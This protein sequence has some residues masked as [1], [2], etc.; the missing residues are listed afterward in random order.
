MGH[1]S[2]VGAGPG[3]ES[4]L[5][6][7]AAELLALADVVIIEQ[8]EQAALVTNGAE[9]VDGGS[10]EDGET[11][12][13]AARARIVVR[14]AKTGAQVVRLVAGDPFTY[15]TAPEEA[16]ACTKAGIGFEIVPGISSV[17]AVP[18]YAGVPLTNRTH[19]EYT[20]VNVG[21]AKVNWSDHAGSDTLV[22]LA[23]VSRIDE[24]ATGLI[25][26]G[27]NA[28][29]P[30]A[31]TRVGTTT[32]QST[33]VSTLQDIAADA[34]AAGMTSPAITVVGAVVSMRETLSW[35]E[36]KPLYG[37]RVLVPRTKEQSAGLARSPAW[38]RCP[39]R[40]GPDHLGRAAAQSA[41]DGQGRARSGRGSL[42]VDRLHQRQR[43]QG[44][45]REVRGVRSRRPRLLGPEDRR[46][47]RQDRRR[48]PHLGHPP[49]SGPDR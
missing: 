33:V 45:A 14:H 48:H 38:L 46:R 36:T 35:F 26:A 5:T 24:V 3:D 25:D 22:L 39:V 32:E 6:V 4:L 29:T 1:V 41:A 23:A 17:S 47:R 34:A 28:D 10:S 16:V 42:R 27:R 49:R 40:G 21:D 9:I 37:W 12:T 20:V 18:A 8:P 13:H 19:R 2:F 43:G 31:M 11:L 7:R 30:V 15:A 44:R